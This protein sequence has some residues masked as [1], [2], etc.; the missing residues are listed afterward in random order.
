VLYVTPEKY[1]TMGFG[2][3]LAGIE[4]VELASILERAAAI[5]DDY[6]TVPRFPSRHTFFGGSVT[7]EQHD[8]TLPESPL[9]QPRRRVWPMHWPILEITDFKVRVTNT[10]Y[11]SIAPSEMFINNASRY[12]EVVS[13]AFTGVGLFGALIPSIGLMRPVAEISYTYGWRFEARSE[14]LY[15]TDARTFR[16]ANQFWNSDTNEPVVYLNGVA[17]N[18]GFTID[19]IEGT[20]TFDNQLAATDVVSADYDYTLPREI[21][22]GVGHI[23]TYL[24]AGREVQSRGM[25]GLQSLKVGE[26]SIVA[27]SRRLTAES[28]PILVPEAASLLADFGFIT[29]R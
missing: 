28:L 19:E 22:E 6:C 26:V 9:E 4:D 10:Q 24:L 11:V 1:R 5:A 21:K 14:M 3:D 17:Q 18:T 7:A 13:L 25:G 8:W 27:P 29:V 2:I 23:A 16:A 12:V 15:P 20:V